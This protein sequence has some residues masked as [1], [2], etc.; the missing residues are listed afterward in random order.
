MKLFSTA[1]RGGDP[2]EHGGERNFLHVDV[3]S[4][5]HRLSA[6]PFPY[7]IGQGEDGGRA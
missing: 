2:A 5:R 3:I 6:V 1:K 4:P 7:A